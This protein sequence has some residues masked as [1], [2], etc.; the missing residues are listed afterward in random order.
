MRWLSVLL[1]II[2]CLA[3]PDAMAGAWQREPGHGFASTAVRLSWPQDV[4]HWTSRKPTQTYYTLYVEYGVTPRLTLGLDLGL[5]GA[6]F[7]AA[8]GAHLVLH[9]DRI[10]HSLVAAFEGLQKDGFLDL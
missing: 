10:L 1:A 5:V 7:L 6:L 8:G 4:T 3:A 2:A 9:A